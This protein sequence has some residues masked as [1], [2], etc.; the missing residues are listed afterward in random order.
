M[1]RR[2]PIRLPKRTKRRRK[3][4]E[5]WLVCRPIDVLC[6]EGAADVSLYTEKERAMREAREMRQRPGTKWKVVVRRV[7]L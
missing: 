1:K 5:A 2:G 7:V 3:P 4:I 6:Y